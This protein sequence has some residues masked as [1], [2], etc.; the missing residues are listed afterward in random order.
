MVN[1]EKIEE[2]D[3][4][5]MALEAGA[6]DVKRADS[7]YE[8]TTTA[9]NFETVKE[10]LVEQEIEMASVTMIP[11]TIVNLEG[12]QAQQMLKLL[13]AL[14]DHDDVQQVYANFDISEEIMAEMSA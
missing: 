4:I 12:K 9:E 1:T 3:L 13:E 5:L 8:V 14:E 6:E 2:D 7:S 11:Q 10:A